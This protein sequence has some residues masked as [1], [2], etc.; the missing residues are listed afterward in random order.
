M[1][2]NKTLDILHKTSKK[3]TRSGHVPAR[4][5][6]VGITKLYDN[7]GRWGKNANFRGK[8]W[9]YYE[10]GRQIDYKAKAN[11]DV[12]ILVNPRGTSSK[13]AACGGKMI[14]EERRVMRCPVGNITVDRDKNASANILVRGLEVGHVGSAS[15]AMVRVSHGR[16]SLVVE[17]SVDADQLTDSGKVPESSGKQLTKVN[18]TLELPPS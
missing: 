5:D 17:P 16:T 9:G 2:R 12:S 3:I 1:G 18:T 4:E 7:P 13:C 14:T 15:E 6:L 11:G 8:N 10:L